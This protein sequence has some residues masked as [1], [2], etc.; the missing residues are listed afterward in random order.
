M[1]AAL[2]Y[3]KPVSVEAGEAA[4]NLVDGVWWNSKARLPDYRLVLRRNIDV[5]DEIVPWLVSRAYRSPKMS[6]WVNRDADDEKP[7][8]L[9]RQE[10]LHGINF[11]DL[12]T[13]QIDVAVPDPFPFPRMGSKQIT[14]ED[15][16][17]IINAVRDFAIKR[18][19]PGA[20]QPE[21][22]VQ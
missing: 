18:L 10:A 22:M 11:S 13:L 7:L 21:R 8:V 15:F 5:G 4:A 1:R 20:T 3:L 6:E 14:Q 12:A 17:G 19:G 16:P 9:H 2:K